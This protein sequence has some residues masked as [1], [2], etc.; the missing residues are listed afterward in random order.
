MNVKTKTHQLPWTLLLSLGLFALVRPVIKVL[1]DVFGYDVPSFVTM[2]ITV[3]IAVVWIAIVVKLKVEKPIIVLALS[4]VVYAVSSVIMAVVIR[5]LFPNM[6]DDEVNIPTLLTA[7][8]IASIFF[9]LMYGAFL[10][11][12]AMLIQRASR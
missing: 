9:N 11:F 8:L 3:A 1:G 10:G 5:L 12:V 4:G 2:V 6:G 7:G